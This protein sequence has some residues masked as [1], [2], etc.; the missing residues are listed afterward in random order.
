MML[1]LHLSWEPFLFYDCHSLTPQTTPL[2]PWD[3]TVK[4]R[5][6]CLL[7]TVFLCGICFFISWQITYYNVIKDCA[8]LELSHFTLHHQLWAHPLKGSFDLFSL[9]PSTPT[10]S[11]WEIKSRC[12]APSFQP[13]HKTC[14]GSQNWPHLH[15]NQ[16]RE[17]KGSS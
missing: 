16:R 14:R 10:H 6:F 15:W 13:R 5:L 3:S 12:F 7:E 9:W 1:H 8:I 17:I 4:H 2:P 11:L